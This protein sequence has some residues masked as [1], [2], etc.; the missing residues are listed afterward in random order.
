[1]LRFEQKAQLAERRQPQ[2]AESRL[3]T[4]FGAWAAGGQ[5]EILTGPAESMISAKMCSLSLILTPSV[6]LGSCVFLA[7]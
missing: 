7:A 2:R 6:C 3:D 5:E 4:Y 1:M